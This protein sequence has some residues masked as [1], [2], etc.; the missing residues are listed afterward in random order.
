MGGLQDRSAIRAGALSRY[1]LQ[2]DEITKRYND[3]RE[4][5]VKDRRL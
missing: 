2:N 3:E 4:F 5:N 1:F